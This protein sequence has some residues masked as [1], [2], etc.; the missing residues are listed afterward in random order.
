MK[1]NDNSIEQEKPSAQTAEKIGQTPSDKV[2]IDAPY[3]AQAQDILRGKIASSDE[4]LELTKKLKSVKAFN[5]ARR[6][7]ARAADCTKLKQ[8]DPQKL[9]ICQEWAL[10]TYKDSDLPADMR[11]DE[12]L[13]ILSRTEDLAETKNQETLGLVGAIYK[14]KWEVD[15][16]KIQLERSLLYYTR[17]YGEG[18]VNDQGYTG[19]NAAFNLDLLAHQEEA[20]SRKAKTISAT[21]AERKIKARNIREDIVETVAPLLDKN[22]W[23]QGAWWFYSTIAEAYFGLKEYEKAVEWL[24]LGRE[25]IGEIPDWELE[26]TIRQMAR[27][28]NLHS[29]SSLSV[30]QCQDTDAWK[31]L[32]QFFDSP[33]AFH[34]AFIGKIGLGLSGGGFRASLFH[35]GTLAKLAELGVLRHVEVLSCV[36]GGS[37]IGAHYYLEVRKLLQS[38]PDKEITDEDYINI[39]KKIEKDFLEGVKQ[40]IRMRVAAEIKTNVKMVL[41]PDYTRSTRVAELYESEIFSKVDDGG[42]GKWRY[43]DELKTLPKDEPKNFNPKLHNWRRATKVPILILNATTLNTGHNWQFTTT[44]M[45][46]PPSSIKTE[47]D[48][49][50][51]LRRMYYAETPDEYKEKKRIRLGDAVAASA[52]VPGLFDPVALDNLY[53][54]RVVRLVDGGVCDNQGLNSLLE[55]DCTVILISD[56]SGQMASEHLPSNGVVGVPLRSNSILQARIRDTQYHDLERR[57]RSSLLRGLMFIHLKQDLDTDPVDWI[58]CADP[59]AGSTDARDSSRQGILASYGIAK[60]TQKRLAAIRTDLDSF[61][62]V[63]AYALMTSAY[64]MTENAFKNLKCVEGFAEPDKAADWNFLEIEDGMKGT[65]KKYRHVL[66]LLDVSNSLPLKIWKMWW[67][68]WSQTW[69]LK[70]AAFLLSLVVLAVI[71]AAVA[72]PIWLFVHYLSGY[73]IAGTT[74]GTIVFGLIIG[75][76]ALYIFFGVIQVLRRKKSPSQI[77]IGIVLSL[78][79]WFTARLHLWIFDKMFLRRGSIETFR[80]QP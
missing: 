53:P 38:K 9:R 2:K 13:D 80:Q 24:N 65:G 43:L 11:L 4:V 33:D 79:G 34:S 63:E 32:R 52:C 76:L 75:I 18:A 74:L 40:N 55:Q 31:A 19:I 8:D 6:I 64:R 56:G 49:N 61:S 51:Q 45:G 57:K 54:E 68:F 71:V 35:I 17:G 62:D 69:Y 48:T 3:I 10:C 7:L 15:N 50:D 58:D 5:Y 21:A 23:L 39:V 14:R 70:L 37:I 72:L 26:A 12:A 29:D 1:D 27:L 66:K 77:V 30:K 42:A 41:F 59:F 22:D 16:Q 47:V 46:E 20:E 73:P 25:K 44:W 60:E 36:S 78:F 67:S 28:A